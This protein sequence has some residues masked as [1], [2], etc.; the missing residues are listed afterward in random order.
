MEYGVV[1]D[2]SGVK[3]PPQ[4]GGNQGSMERVGELPSEDAAAEE[5]HDHGQIEPALPGGDVGD[6]ADQVG[7]GSLGRRGLGQ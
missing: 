5:I 4:G 6:V 2:Q 7:A 3:S 1:L